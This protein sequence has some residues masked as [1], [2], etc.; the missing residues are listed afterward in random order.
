[1]PW[2]WGREAAKRQ[3]LADLPLICEEVRVTFGLAAGDIPAVE[4]LRE[5]LKFLDFSSFPRLDPGAIAKLDSVLREDIP[6][7]MRELDGI[8]HAQPQPSE[9]EAAPPAPVPVPASSPTQSPASRQNPAK[10][11]APLVSPV[12]KPKANGERGGSSL[13]PVLLMALVAVVVLAAVGWYLVSTK[14]VELPPEWAARLER[15]ASSEGFVEPE[16]PTLA[17][18]PPVFSFGQS[19]PPMPEGPGEL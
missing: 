11:K 18:E 17:D 2:V 6:H 9:P 4:V 14:A 13:L 12:V 10:P 7:L 19:D 1:M 3:L 5:R 16:P 8:T 15:L